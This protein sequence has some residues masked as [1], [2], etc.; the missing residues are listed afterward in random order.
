VLNSTDVLELGGD[1]SGTSILHVSMRGRAAGPEVFVKTTQVLNK[2][3]GRQIATAVAGHLGFAP[4]S[5]NIRNDVYFVGMGFPLRF[6]FVEGDMPPVEAMKGT[7]TLRCSSHNG[8]IA[9]AS[10]WE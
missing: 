8:D 4:W 9:C 3:V 2:N 5:V 7:V 10:I 1:L 6:P